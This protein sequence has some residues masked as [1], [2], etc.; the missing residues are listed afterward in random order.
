[1]PTAELSG[2]DGDMTHLEFHPSLKRDTILYR[3]ISLETF[4]AFVESKRTHLTK[5]TEWDDPWEAVLSKIPVVDDDGKPLKRIYSYHEGVFG[6]CWSLL[7][8]SDAMWRIYSRSN[9]GLVMATTLEKFELLRGAERL[10]VGRVVYFEDPRDLVAKAGTGRSTFEG[11]CFKRTVYEHEREVRVLTH[12]DF[13]SGCDC[14]AKYLALDVDPLA[15]VD[16]II[17][18]PRAASW[19]V[20]AMKEY[21]RRSGFSIEPMQSDLYAP[22]PHLTC[23]LVTK[24]V[25]AGRAKGSTK[26]DD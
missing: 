21:C 24:Y 20:D 9:T 7:Q 10:Y 3:Y 22:D 17:V 6:Q 25:P 11:F 15:F 19:F 1:M 14:K 12:A 18:D 4:L 13:V 23:G 8:E 26:I 16:R 2:A 5:V